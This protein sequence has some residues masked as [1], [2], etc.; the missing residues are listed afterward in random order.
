M[1]VWGLLL[2]LMT[3]TMWAISPIMM[4]IG[5]RR[6]GPNEVNPIRS[7]GFLGTMALIMLFVRPDHMPTMTPLLALGLLVNVG[8]STVLGDQMYIYAINVLPVSVVTPIT[9]SSP[10]VT[11]LI[12]RLIYKEKLS[13]LQNAG[14]VLVSLGSLAVSL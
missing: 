4:K 8:S 10:F 12:A 6:A 3:A 14:I 2:S 13:K 9:A 5:M 11:V 7:F 1:P